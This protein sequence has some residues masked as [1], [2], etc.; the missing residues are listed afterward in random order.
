MKNP[1]F[2]IIKG[3]AIML[4]VLSHSG[5]PGTLANII[6]QFHVAVFFI[7]MGYFFKT[8][9]LNAEKTYIV[10]RFKSLYIPFLKYA[11]FFLVCHNLFYIIGL[12]NSEHGNGGTLTAHWYTW[13]NFCQRLWHI[14]TNMSGYDEFL[15]GSFWFFRALL[16]SSILYLIAFKLLNK[17]KRLT[18][19][20]TLINICITCIFLLLAA[21]K[22]NEGLNILALGS[23]GAREIIGTSLIAI[24]FLYRRITEVNRPLYVNYIIVVLSSLVVVFFPK[25]VVTNMAFYPNVSQILTL[26][27]PAVAGFILLHGIS[28]SITKHTSWLQSRIAYIGNHSLSIFA[29]H[30]LA[31]KVVSAFKVLCYGLPWL[32]VGGHTVV[33][34]HPDDAFYILYFIV[35]V[36]LP[37]LTQYY[38]RCIRAKYRLTPTKC[39]HRAYQGLCYVIGAC[40]ALCKS[41]YNYIKNSIKGFLSELKEII[42]AG[43]PKEE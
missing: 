20:H 1:T 2:S 11:I 41:I 30:L 15:A 33:H 14:I 35:G 21:W 3:L 36:S 4:V 27:I 25:F 32:M 7:S 34:A 18:N 26:P 42:S 38:I 24:G 29:F 9:Y 10:R 17:I 23:G 8:S 13:H 40:G 12:I 39:A 6:F 28:A 22:S 37:L 43:N 16:I 19:R 31:F 5:I